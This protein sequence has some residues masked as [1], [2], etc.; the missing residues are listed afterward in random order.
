MQLAVGLLMILLSRLGGLRL[1]NIRV[2]PDIQT[3]PMNE[4]FGRSDFMV[5]NHRGRA[6]AQR[7]KSSNK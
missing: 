6:I 7:L 2:S 4:T 1:R 5:F 3:K